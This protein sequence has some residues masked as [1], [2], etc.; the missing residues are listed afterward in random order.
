LRLGIHTSIA[1]SLENAA[2]KAVALGANTFQIFSASPRMWAGGALD[3]E[4]ARRLRAARERHDLRPFVIHAGYLINLASSDA[5]VRSRSIRAF[6][7][8]LERAVL[9]GADYL[10]VHPGSAGDQSREEALQAVALGLQEAARRIRPDGLTILLENT[11]GSGATL[12]GTFEELQ[13]I[14]QIALADSDLPLGFCLDTCHLLAAGWDVTSQEGVT[15]TFRQ[16]GERLGWP[17]I[18]LIHANDSKT[19][20]GSHIDRHAPIGEGYIG[21]AGFRW[22]LQHPQLRK[23][24]FILETPV[25]HPG[26]DRRNLDMLKALSAVPRARDRGCS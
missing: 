22:I 17:H 10:V 26:D 14:R 13:S 23:L 16:A 4:S 18:H 8:E 3:P 15:E 12:G 9:L 7:G 2:R 24:P 20:L 6:H 11:A 1:G 5:A 25:Q 19:P 21:K